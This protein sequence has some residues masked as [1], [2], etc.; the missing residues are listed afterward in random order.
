M[1]FFQSVF[2]KEKNKNTNFDTTVMTERAS[3]TH[4]E[5]FL[6]TDLNSHT[7]KCKKLQIKVEA[8]HL[9]HRMNLVVYFSQN[10]DS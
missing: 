2:L 3:R 1:S 6:Q 7:M 4:P 9:F 8:I 10:N 5:G